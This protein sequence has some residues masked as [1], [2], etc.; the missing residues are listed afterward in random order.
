MLSVAGDRETKLVADDLSV[1]PL[2]VAGRG[3]LPAP[4]KSGFWRV[5]S[6]SSS[7]RSH[8]CGCTQVSRGSTF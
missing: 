2:N 7:L 6:G 5:I 8:S 3:G 1:H 4:L